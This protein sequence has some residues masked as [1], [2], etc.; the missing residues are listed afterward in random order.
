MDD[1]KARTVLVACC[2]RLHGLGFVPATDGNASVL[3]ARGRILLTP[4]GREKRELAEGDLLVVDGEGR[5]LE[6]EGQP[7]T[8]TAVHLLC[9]RRRSDVGAVVH[10]HPPVATAFAVAGVPLEAAVLPEGVA[11]VGG[12]PTVQ[13]ATPGTGALA[14]AFE[15]WIG[16][17]DA[18][19]LASHGALTLGTGPE[20][21]LH[22]ME[23]LEHL[24]KVTLAARLLG[25][26]ILLTD[27]ER[28][29]LGAGSGR[30]RPP[31]A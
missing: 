8:E 12:I 26:P 21:A 13:Y 15:P 4:P 1:A 25:G 7:S 23:R 3:L 31:A 5:V 11:T 28:V 18:F 16:G 19:L 30:P 24:A 10:A 20:E 27:E 2:R 22:R 17:Y 9:Y 29:A 14:R 6:G